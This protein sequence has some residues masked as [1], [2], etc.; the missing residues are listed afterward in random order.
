MNEI[1]KVHLGRQAFTI[2]VDAH[3]ELQAYLAEIKQQVGNNKDVIE[4]IELRMA[5]LLTER[6]I[7]DSKV[8]LAKDVAYLKGQLGEPR[9]FG[10]DQGERHHAKTEP[11]ADSP[12]RLFRD[13]ENGM[14]AG[15][16]AGLAAYLN[17]DP[18]IIRL[19]F[20][21]L[22]LS[23]GAGILVYVLLWLL[24][25]PVKS[26]SDR[27]QMHGKAVTVDNIKEAISQA[28][29]AG[30]ASRA[31][32]TVARAG[33]GMVKVALA[34]LGIGFIVGGTMTLLAG[35]T[36]LIF[37]LVHGVQLGGQIV[38]PVG[39]RE[40][41]LML[42]GFAVLLA[43]A[44]LAMLSGRAM[45]RRKWGVP[46]W[47]AAALVVLF[48]AGSAAGT[49]TGFAIAPDVRHRVAGVQHS[50]WRPMPA[51]TQ[52]EMRMPAVNYGFV[53]DAHY[54]VDVRT[55]GSIDTHAITASV[56]NGQ[57]IVDATA[58][59]PKTDS[60]FLVCPYGPTNVEVIVHAPSPYSGNVVGGN[61]DFM[62]DAPSWEDTPPV[63]RYR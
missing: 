24:V 2:A 23:G 7:T 4:E 33:A 21:L 26:G 34:I 53:S 55:I 9:D 60:C 1:T 61:R 58:F 56:S 40:F 15:V 35:A 48:I 37:G 3:K 29:V 8:V 19:I 57:L 28:D 41:A 52:V 63:P 50:E 43:L 36:A 20:V 38:F 16:A 54:G 30:A 44:I 13:P 32:S 6:G 49:A 39:S 45:I 12:K 18:I 22:V 17:I 25:P 27:L 46:G 59:H 31:G 5:E 11:A 47:G 51:F 62:L 10:D 14:I 42:S